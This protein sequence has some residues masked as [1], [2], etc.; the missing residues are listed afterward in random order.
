[1][2]CL[3]VVD[4]FK[5]FVRRHHSPQ[6]LLLLLLVAPDGH[7]RVH[8]VR[9]EMQGDALLERDHPSASQLVTW[10]DLLDVCILDSQ[11]AAT[12]VQ[13]RVRFL[14]FQRTDLFPRQSK[15][16]QLLC[17]FH[18]RPRGL[19][20]HFVLPSKPDH[21]LSTLYFCL[22]RQVAT[23]HCVQFC[24][25]V[26]VRTVERCLVL[27][28]QQFHQF[29]VLHFTVVGSRHGLQQLLQFVVRYA[30][31]QSL[32]GSKMNRARI[33]HIQ[34]IHRSQSCGHEARTSGPKTRCTCSTV[35][36]PA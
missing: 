23:H 30:E 3:S 27:H 36:V 13:C 28:A 7:V 33:D 1:M 31:V 6:R 18:E 9:P 4:L 22:R 15:L 17:F 25:Q 21:S 2:C 20:I 8:R 26:E 34:Q 19:Y 35:T 32:C 29:V 10:I 5:Q 16:Q 11:S 24:P 12:T 14:R